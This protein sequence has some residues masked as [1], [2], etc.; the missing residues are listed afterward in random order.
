MAQINDDYLKLMAGYLFPEIARRVT[1]FATEN[2]STRII[3]L[4]IGD[5]T[6]PLPTA[7]IEAMQTQSAAPPT[8]VIVEDHLYRPPPP[9]PYYPPHA[10]V[11]F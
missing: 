11:H 5:V 8:P 6:R 7:V 1:K 10:C 2:P 3:R 4:G 9:P